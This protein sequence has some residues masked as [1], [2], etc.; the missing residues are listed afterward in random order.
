MFN[1]H[2][3]HR[4]VSYSR[5][6]ILSFRADVCAVVLP[7]PFIC[8]WVASHATASLSM[9]SLVFVSAFV[10]QWDCKIFLIRKSI[11]QCTVILMRDRMSRVNA[12]VSTLFYINLPLYS[13]SMVCLWAVTGLQISDDTRI[14]EQY[15]SDADLAEDTTSNFKKLLL[16]AET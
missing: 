6:H 1:A 2:C 16:G 4:R 11:T 9:M 12:L 10:S 13:L 3:R 5:L 15:K 7:C 8:F 14:F